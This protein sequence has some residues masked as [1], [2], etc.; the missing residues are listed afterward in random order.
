MWKIDFAN[1]GRRIKRHH[2]RPGAT[3]RFAH[4]RSRPQQGS[5][6][7]VAQP[8]PVDDCLGERYA[9]R[10]TGISARHQ[11]RPHRHLQILPE[12]SW[13][14]RFVPQ[15]GQRPVAGDETTRGNCPCLCPETKSFAARRAVWDARFDD[16]GRI[17]GR[18]DRCVVERANH[19]HYGYPRCG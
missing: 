2:F 6:V 19:G 10:E 9:W 7:S 16:A 5:G 4:F 14:G 15:E 18:I 11:T 17:A 1:H 13:P 12:Q 8:F 3:R